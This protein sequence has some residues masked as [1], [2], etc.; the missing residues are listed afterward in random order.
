MQSIQSVSSIRLFFEEENL[1]TSQIIEYS[2]TEMALSELRSRYKGATYDLSTTAGD[3]A[4][5]AARAEVKGY[6]VALEKMRTELKAPALERSRL[7]D[8]EAKRI[9]AELLAL[10]EPIDAQIKAAEQAAAAEKAEK[11]RIEAERV[12]AIRFAIDG[13]RA[14]ASEAVGS[15]SDV[16][17][18]T[19]SRIE[20]KEISLVLYAEFTGEAMQAKQQTIAALNDLHEKALAHEAEQE[21]IKQERAELE[22][23]RAAQAERERVAA[24]ERAEAEAKVKAE[25]EAY[26]AKI[27]AEQ[28]AQEAEQRRIAKEQADA[29]AEIDRQRRELEEQQRA[30]AQAEADRIAAVEREKQAKAEA[31]AKAKREQEERAQREAFIADGPGAVELLK[32]V[33]DHYCVDTAVAANWLAKYDFS[34]LLEA[35]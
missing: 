15:R 14:I 11:A 4:A 3:K 12:A 17:A 18:E 22:A 7:I 27:L 35:A 30:I 2:Q 20:S 33:A 19:I 25:Q 9:T 21:R 6:R 10:E 16:I 26:A 28:A 13:I 24:Q 1:M 31:K 8:A 34:E 23:L 32:L 5:R 29:Q